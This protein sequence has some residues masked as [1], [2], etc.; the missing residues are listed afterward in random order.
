VLGCAAGL[1]RDAQRSWGVEK[2]AHADPVTGARIVELATAGV[3]T[4]LYIHFS[5]FTADNRYLILKARSC[6]SPMN[7]ASR[8]PPPARIP[9]MPGAST[10]CVRGAVYS[11][12]VETFAQRKIA[13]LP[14]RGAL[15][16][17]LSKDG[18]TMAFGFQAGENMWEI[19]VIDIAT[20]KYRRV[21]QQGFRIGHV[22]HSPTEPV[23]FYAWE[24]GGYA[25]QRTWLV[26]ADG[27]GN[28]PF[29]ANTEPPK[30]L[31][32][33]KEWITHEAWVPAT[34]QMTMIQ[35]RFGILLAKPS[36]EW[37]VVTKG[38]YWHTA[39][40]VDGKRLIADDFDGK[41]WL[42]DVATGSA[43]L[44]RAMAGGRLV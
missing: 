11:I 23:I 39:S 38:W 37:R 31:T 6:N 12:D 25:A 43:K 18:K 20:G 32:P 27:S 16:P 22:Q 44:T 8:P 9:P 15:Q 30:W 14:G 4:N 42:I 28:R 34:G 33:L 3:S 40:T 10:F 24:T 36:G 19:G 7:R 35:D 13:Y 41:L 26:N 29:Y 1:G 17:A 2:R 21:I 5:N